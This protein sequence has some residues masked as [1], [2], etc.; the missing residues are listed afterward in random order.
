MVDVAVMKIVSTPK[1]CAKKFAKVFVPIQSVFL[2]VC[3]RIFA[4]NPNDKTIVLDDVG[5]VRTCHLPSVIG[6]CT[7]FTNRWY[8]DGSS[9]KQFS[10][11]GCQGNE[12]NFESQTD[13]EKTCANIP[14]TDCLPF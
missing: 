8:Y 11:G 2:I 9:C 7:T 12:N 10:Y 13:C 5:K 3:D 4:G 1:S 6:P 14:G